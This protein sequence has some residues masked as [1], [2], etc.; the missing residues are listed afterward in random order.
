MSS[1]AVKRERFEMLMQQA[2]V[3]ADVVNSFFRM[4]ISIES[5]QPARIGNGRFIS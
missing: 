5:K 2:H 4:D 3:P 1:T